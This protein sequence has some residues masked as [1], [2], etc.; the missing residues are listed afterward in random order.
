M[1]SG[2]HRPH[3]GYAS[4]L[5][6]LSLVLLPLSAAAQ[7]TSTVLQLGTPSLSASP[8][9][10]VTL[11]MRFNAVPMA[12]DYSV[13]VHFVDSNGTNHSGPDADH[14]P[15]VG[16]SR[17]S[18]AVAY[19]HTVTLPASMPHGTYSIR[20][21][22]FQNHSPWGRAALT[23]GTGVT[24][25]DQ[26]RYTVGTLT[27]GSQPSTTSTV[28]RLGSPS[29]SSRPG[30]AVT[31]AMRFNAVPMAEDYYVFVHFVDQNG[32]QHS[33]LNADHLPPVGTSQW[34]GAIAYNISKTLPIQL[35]S[36]TYTLR[37]GLYSMAAPNNRIPLT[38]G[39]GVTADGEGRYIVGTLTVTSTSEVV[40]YYGDS[41][42]WGYK[43]GVGTRVSKPAPAAFAEAL[44]QV[45]VRNEGVSGTTACGLLNGTD[46]VHP[47]WS[48]QMS[49]SNATTVIINHAINDQWT[50]SLATYKSC[51]TSL[52]QGAKSRGKRV[53]FETPNPTRDS[54]GGLETYVA[55][56]KE[57]AAQ[58]Q[59]SVIDQYQ[60]LLDYL[61]GR[62][63]YDICPDGLHPSDAVYEM[64]GR[65]AADVFKTLP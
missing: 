64:K 39:S 25:D 38:P 16:T 15:P 60:Y 49:N 37:V 48:T 3:A 22:L 50:Y 47:A 62:S 58:Q 45:Q 14:L 63:P 32:V 27:V 6:L 30:Q 44:P 20:V 51:L 56:M 31:L 33:T 46:G 65:Y 13:F 43:T 4:L 18:G 24:V 54:G 12:E 55:A 23:R 2:R 40:D 36:G 1:R 35:T 5:A 28:L 21:G 57:V 42:V 11:A 34:S 9:Q 8:G 52:A 26:L 59:L 7:Q 41:T 61:N 19:N 53:I 17:W 29:L 10:N